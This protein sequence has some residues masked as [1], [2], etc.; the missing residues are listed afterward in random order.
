MQGN[1][2]KMAATRGSTFDPR[3]TI[4]TKVTKRQMTVEILED[5]PQR[6]MRA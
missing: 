2:N 4:S 1:A 5:E 3:S 6:K